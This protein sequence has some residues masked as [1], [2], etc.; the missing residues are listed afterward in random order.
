MVTLEHKV[1]RHGL[2]WPSGQ[3]PIM[4][5]ESVLVDVVAA[6]EVAKAAGATKVEMRRIAADRLEIDP[7]RAIRPHWVRKLAKKFDAAST[8]V[9]HVSRRDGG[10]LVVIEGNHRVLAARAAGQNKAVL[11]CVVYSGLSMVQEAALYRALEYK[12]R[13]SPLDL[14]VARIQE[15]E[16]VAQDMANRARE[17]GISIR[18]VSGGGRLT[19]G[20]VQRA[21]SIY[22]RYGAQMYSLVL[23]TAKAAWSDQRNVF[24]GSVIGGLARFLRV[25]G[26][27]IDEATLI[28]RLSGTTPTQVRQKGKTLA[29]A[30]GLSSSY[31]WEEGSG[32]AIYGIYNYNLRTKALPKWPERNVRDHAADEGEA[33][34]GR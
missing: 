10:R 5:K 11:T 9:L 22:L 32:R 31:G 25:F 28:R 18:V 24:D 6:Q 15:G 8:G 26:D 19:L 14:F 23:R 29:D 13:Q 7:I 3:P 17:L 34:D 2:V 16:P 1:D 21:E 4:E 33:G 20:A 12:L 27:A 30:L